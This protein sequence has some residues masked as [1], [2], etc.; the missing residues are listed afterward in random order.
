MERS[1][2]D[3]KC[4]IQVNCWKRLSKVKKDGKKGKIFRFIANTNSKEHEFHNFP[5]TVF[6]YKTQI[7]F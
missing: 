4:K 7:W 2:R 6:F 1:F 5:F 3:I